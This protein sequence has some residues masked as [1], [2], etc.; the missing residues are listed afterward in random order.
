MEILI[1]RGI[2][3]SGKSTFAKDWVAKDSV[4]RIRLNRDDIRNSFGPYWVPSRELLITRVM[5][6][7]LKQAIDLGY[8]VVIDNMNLD[9]KYFNQLKNTIGEYINPKF[10]YQSDPITVS[11]IDFKTPLEECIKRDSLR[12]HPIGEKV[13]RDTY[14]KYINFYK[15]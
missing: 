13:I 12:E 5:N 1:C 10:L 3:G 7:A 6:D 14:K 4:N 15:E 8:S 9:K 11:I 2:Q